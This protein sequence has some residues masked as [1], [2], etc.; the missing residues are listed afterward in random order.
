[1]AVSYTMYSLSGVLDVF[2][3]Q[4]K[5]LTTLR[6]PTTTLQSLYYLTLCKQNTSSR[7]CHSSHSDHNVTD[8]YNIMSSSRHQVSHQSRRSYWPQRRQ[9]APLVL[10]FFEHVITIDLEIDLFWKRGFSGA[11]D[12]FLANR[13]LIL[14]ESVLALVP[15]FDKFPTNQVS[16]TD[17]I[18]AT[19][20]EADIFAPH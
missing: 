8:L 1:M 20:C 17:H 15:I 13:Y 7:Q 11:A 3:S 6:R 18:L 16:L 19:P 12:L 4:S 2:P 14:M 5:W 9:R 10:I